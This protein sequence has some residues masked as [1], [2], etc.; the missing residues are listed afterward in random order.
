M[1]AG[2]GLTRADAAAGRT[3]ARSMWRPPMPPTM[4]TATLR[5]LRAT[6]TSVG[7]VLSGTPYVASTRCAVG[8]ASLVVVRGAPCSRRLFPEAAWFHCIAS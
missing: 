4:G 3:T 8:E 1:A 2:S 7:R 6:P 5:A